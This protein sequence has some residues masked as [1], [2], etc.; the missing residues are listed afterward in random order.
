MPTPLHHVELAL[1]AEDT[2][3]IATSRK[4]TLLV[5]YL[6]PYSSDLKLWLSERRIAINVSKAPR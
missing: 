2:T 5:S 4:P 6:D 1:Y 3:I